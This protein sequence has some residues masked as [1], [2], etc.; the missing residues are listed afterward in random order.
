MADKIIIKMM[1]AKGREYTLENF[2]QSS[3][4]HIIDYNGDYLGNITITEL[5]TIIK[6]RREYINAIQKLKEEN[7][8]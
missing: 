3:V 2:G 1:D 5:V 6:K 7:K 8:I 4:I